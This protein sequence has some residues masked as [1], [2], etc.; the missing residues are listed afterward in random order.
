M[1]QVKYARS[2][3]IDSEFEVFMFVMRHLWTLTGTELNVLAHRAEISPQTLYNWRTGY[4][5]KPRID[6]ISKVLRAMGYELTYR[7]SKAAPR[8]RRV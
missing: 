3:E 2:T 7:K 1:G 8:L 5:T 6:T 4:V